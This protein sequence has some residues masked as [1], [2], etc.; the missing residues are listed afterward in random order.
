[1]C[2]YMVVTYIHA[3]ILQGHTIYG[4]EADKVYTML[5]TIQLYMIVATRLVLVPYHYHC[6]PHTQREEEGQALGTYC[7]HRPC[8]A[9]VGIIT[10][11]LTNAD[12]SL[13][14]E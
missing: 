14:L 11:L 13:S 4:S 3:A 2:R 10:H 5:Y 8:H 12:I 6:A 7:M 1:M 9:V